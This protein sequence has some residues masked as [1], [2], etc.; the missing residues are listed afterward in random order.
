MDEEHGDIRRLKP[1]AIR[2]KTHTNNYPVAQTRGLY[3]QLENADTKNLQGRIG[4]IGAG[5]CFHRR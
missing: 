1:L 5:N 4:T 2:W 3:T